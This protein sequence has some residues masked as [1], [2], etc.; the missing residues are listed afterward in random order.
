MNANK[1]KNDPIKSTM[2]KDIVVALIAGIA[3]TLLAAYLVAPETYHL[4]T[5]N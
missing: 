4:L 5:A 1:A 3:A 2:G